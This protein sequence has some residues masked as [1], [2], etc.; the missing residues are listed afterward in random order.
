MIGLSDHRQTIVA[1]ASAPSSAI[2]GIVRLAGD[3]ATSVLRKII[4]G[5]FSAP[6]GSRRVDV[7]L[8]LPM[9][10]GEIGAAVM[11]WPG[12]RSYCGGPTVEIHTFGSLPILEALVSAVVVAGARPAAPGEF[13][14][15]AFLAGRLDLTQAEAVLGVIDATNKAQ[16]EAALSQLAGNIAIPLQLA[17]SNLLDLLADLEAGLDFVEEDISFIDDDALA[18]GLE[19][20]S[21]IVQQAAS[22]MRSQRRSDAA[23]SIVLR[24]AP[25]AGKSSLLNAIVGRSVAVVS[26]QAGTTRDVVWA[27]ELVAGQ[28]IRIA[29]TAGIETSHDEIGR[30]S[31]RAANE[32]ESTALLVL[33]CVASDAI[34]DLPCK[35]LT[36]RTQVCVATK[37]DL[38]APPL[39]EQLREEGWLVTSAQNEFG[40]D[41]LRIAI[42]KK[43]AELAA[44]QDVGV[45]ATAARCGDAIDRALAALLGAGELARASA[46]HELIAAEMRQALSAIGEITG[47]IY[48]D[49]LLDRVF[50]RFCIGK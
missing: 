21:A 49:D 36:T 34:G 25:N 38:V 30:A 7:R 8:K 29:D 47:A 16:L 2:R 50:S 11:V 15:R 39:R 9:P 27:E 14:L 6:P 10:F 23:T 4:V 18:G 33:Q 35:P 20:A 42:A 44:T 5:D 28:P 26:D 12:Q 13:T 24:G 17:R 31:Q 32:F 19:N 37:S 3:D 40:L 46:G 22:K 43:L 41:D 48:T 1:I 45:T